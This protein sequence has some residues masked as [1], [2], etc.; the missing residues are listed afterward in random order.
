VKSGVFSPEQVGRYAA[1]VDYLMLGLTIVTGLTGTLLAYLIIRF[2]ARYRAGST[3]E[4]GPP[5]DKTWGMEVAW[6]SASL[7][8][9][10][11]FAIWGAHLFVRLY[12]PPADALEIFVVA[13]QWMW[14][15][16]HPGGQREI[17]EL[18]VPVDRPV[19]LVMVS[20]DVIHS[21]FVPAFRVKQD[22]LPGRYETMWFQ[23]TR[24]GTFGLLCAEY[25]GTDHSGML[26][27]IIVQSPPDYQAWLAAQSGDIS[28]AAEG[29]ALFR[30]YGCSGCHGAASGGSTG[31]VGATV[32]AP[33]LEGVFGR[34][35]PLAD[36]T[37]VTADERYIR[38]SI[39][40]PN[41][42]IAAGY[43]PVMPSFAGQIGEDDLLKILAYIK[44]LAD[45]GSQPPAPMLQRTGTTQP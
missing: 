10:I 9:F 38:D 13:K 32:R 15:T 12:T 30:S 40:L 17:N 34:P 23:A 7:V 2:C 28:L 36:G 27:K 31:R 24:T 25:C 33:P 5:D 44:S 4:R 21:F 35:V 1:E 20:Q 22:V 16:Q 42:Q 18:H 45:G 11:G 14:K 43:A 8:I 37:V 29:A 3:I 41:S 26:G 19:R 6:T 39:L